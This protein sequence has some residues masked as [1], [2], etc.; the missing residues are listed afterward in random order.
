MQVDVNKVVSVTYHLEI[1]EGPTASRTFIE[2]AEANNPLTFL[3]GAGSMIPGFEREL[4][5][6]KQGDLFDF[7]VAPEDAYGVPSDDDVVDLP[8]SIFEEEVKQHPDLLTIGNLIP[9]NDGQGHTF[10]G[11]VRSV[12]MDTVTMDFNHPLSGKT[13]H[14][15]GK[16]EMLRDAEPEEISH[17][18][19]HGPGGHHH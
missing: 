10:Q 18:H 7:S 8:Y 2:K 14:F 19:V 15:K 3:F 6:M 13:L 17:G 12:N 1:S 11:K 5:G 4:E 9:M 16:V